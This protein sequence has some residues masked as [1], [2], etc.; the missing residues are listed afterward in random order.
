MDILTFDSIDLRFGQQQILKNIYITC[1]PGKITGLLGRN[2]AGK[3]CLMQVVFGSL[4]AQYKSVRYNGEALLG[5]YI[6][7]QIIAYLPQQYLLPSYITLAK[8]LQLYQVPEENILA[9]FPEIKKVMNNRAD[10]LS[11]GELRLFEVLLILHTKHPFCFL[12][13]PFSGL[14]P[15][16]VSKVQDFIL[17]QKK[18]KGILI[19]DHMHKQVRKICDE[20]Y[21]LASG[22]TYLIRSEDELI[23]RGYLTVV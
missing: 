21:V 4:D 3:S 2:G 16:Q 6:S 19:S 22:Q 14:S 18:N 7:K 10:E 15:I 17:S 5:N 1:E 23:S 9:F 20:L 8:A 12:D 13:E 11:G